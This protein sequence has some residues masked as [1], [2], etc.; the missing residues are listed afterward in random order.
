MRSCTQEK[1]KRRVY[2][3][4]EKKKG[5]VGGDPEPRYRGGEVRLNTLSFFFFSPFLTSLWYMEVP[6]LVV[7]SKLELP[8]YVTATA[9]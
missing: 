2:S 4:R 7:E 9:K 8:P 5:G 6:R 3:P 1:K